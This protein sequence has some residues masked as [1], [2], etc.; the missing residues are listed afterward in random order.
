MKRTRWR[1]EKHTFTMNPQ[2]RP[3]PFPFCQCIALEEP[4]CGSTEPSFPNEVVIRRRVRGRE[5][6]LNVAS[7]LVTYKISS[8]SATKGKEQQTFDLV[9]F[10]QHLVK[11]DYETKS[12]QVIQYLFCMRHIPKSCRILSVD[13]LPSNGTN[14]QKNACEQSCKDSAPS[15]TTFI[16]PTRP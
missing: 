16:L 8:V 6:V 15:M 13:A 9:H 11:S 1:F 2:E 3:P 5:P 4:C 12:A 10:F 14:P 7:Q